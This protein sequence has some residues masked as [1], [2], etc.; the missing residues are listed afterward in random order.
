ME[1]LSL[2]PH[3]PAFRLPIASMRNVFL[4]DDVERK[5]AKLPERDHESLRSVYQRMLSAGP[6]AFR[7][8]RLACPTWVTF[9]NCCPTSMTY[10]TT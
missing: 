8:N 3:T 1:S 7:S 4:P 9:T 5:L 2:V 10:W 6:S